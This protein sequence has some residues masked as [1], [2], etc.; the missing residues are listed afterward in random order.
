MAHATQV[1][2]PRECE[3]G[4]HWRLTIPLLYGALV[5]VTGTRENRWISS[6]NSQGR[7]SSTRAPGGHLDLNIVVLPGHALHPAVVLH[8]PHE[9]QTGAAGDVALRCNVALS[10]AARLS[11]APRSSLPRSGVTADEFI[12]MF[13]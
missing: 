11:I 8:A 7:L 6:G 2:M 13:T 1:G 5:C 9:W 4:W 3:F 12:T 10:L